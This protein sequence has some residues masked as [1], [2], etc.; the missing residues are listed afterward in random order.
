MTSKKLGITGYM[1]TNGVHLSDRY[2]V[3]VNT[4]T[5]TVY[6]V[7]GQMHHFDKEEICNY[8]ERHSISNLKEKAL[9]AFIKTINR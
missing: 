7:H 2:I 8:L 5:G 9:D 6:D 1:T 3:S 4:K